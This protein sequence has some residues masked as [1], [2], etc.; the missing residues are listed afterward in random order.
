MLPVSG[1]AEGNQPEL[2]SLACGETD[3]SHQ[4][5]LRVPQLWL[6]DNQASGVGIGR[7]TSTHLKEWRVL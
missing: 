3:P 7:A 4:T 5:R 6:A 1:S 2:R